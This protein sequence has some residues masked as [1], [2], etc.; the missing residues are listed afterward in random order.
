MVA[1]RFRDSERHVWTFAYE[2]LV[3][4]PRC[5]ACAIIRRRP[6]VAPGRHFFQELDRPHRVVCSHCGFVQNWEW[7][8]RGQWDKSPVAFGGPVDPYFGYPL[9]LSTPASR[10][11]LWAYN[12]KHLD[13]L[14]AFIGA[15]LRGGPR[16]RTGD[17]RQT[18]VEKLPAWIKSAKHRDELLALITELRHRLP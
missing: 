11:V 12:G 2:I 6:D 8:P 3:H 17:Y 9:W 18:L 14:E 4:C 10:G 13:Y 7:K 5:R 15:K 16:G 1:T